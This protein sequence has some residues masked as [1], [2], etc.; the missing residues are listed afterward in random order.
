MT[1]KIEVESQRIQREFTEI[2][3]LVRGT[4]ENANWIV[5]PSTISVSVEGDAETMKD[6]NAD[7]LGLRAYVD[8]SGIVTPQAVVPVYVEKKDIPGVEVIFDAD[9]M[10]EI[11]RASE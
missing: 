5:S 7:T 11:K 1:V 3:V 4:E 8:V 6:L 2:P 10:A 9:S